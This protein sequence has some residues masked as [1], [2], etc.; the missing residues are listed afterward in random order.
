MQFR[1]SLI[2]PG[3]FMAHGYCCMR[4]PGLVGAF[5]VSY[6]L[7]VLPCLSIPIAFVHFV[8]WPRDISFHWMPVF[9]GAF[10]TVCSSTNIMEARKP[11]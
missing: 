2:F 7:I 6:S 9:C 4:S 11:A 10:A 5:L 8:P 1:R 3:G